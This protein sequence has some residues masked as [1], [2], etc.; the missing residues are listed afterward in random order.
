MTEIGPETKNCIEARELQLRFTHKKLL[1][2]YT[3]LMLEHFVVT[4]RPRKTSV[5]FTDKL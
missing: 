2:T 3:N 1:C 5:S 4:R